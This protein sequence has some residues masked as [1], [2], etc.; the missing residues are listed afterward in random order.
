MR[1]IKLAGAY[2]D[3]HDDGLTVT[4]YDVGEVPACAQDSEE[5]QARAQALGY[6]T[7][8]PRMSRDHELTH[9]MLAAML[10]LPHSPTLY[11]VASKQVY[12]DWMLEESAVL[13]IQAFARAN[14]VDLTTLAIRMTTRRQ[15]HRSAVTGRFI[16]KAEAEASPETTVREQG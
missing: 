15:R 6:G 4:R 10:G 11:G 2:I 13:G 12:P 8:T 7:D 16:S 5:Y 1:T 3:M 14:G 9:H